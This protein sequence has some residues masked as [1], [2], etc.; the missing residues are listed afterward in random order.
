ME[1]KIPESWIEMITV[2][3]S[4]KIKFSEQSVR[5]FAFHCRRG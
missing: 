2:K 4:R 1:N 5:G 3:I